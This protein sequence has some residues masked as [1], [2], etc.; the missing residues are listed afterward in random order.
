MIRNVTSQITDVAV[1]VEPRMVL[2]PT[3]PCI[4]MWPG[5]P[6]TD[7]E[8]AGFGEVRGGFLV[9]VRCRV[10]PVDNTAGQ[11]LLLAFGDDEDDLSLT[12]ALTDDP[13][14]NGHGSL[15]VRS[16]SGWNLFPVPNGES[17]VGFLIGVEVIKAQS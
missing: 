10:S 17:L 1:Q 6:A 14:L 11:D 3:P 4:D 15:D 8:T 7:P 5:D 13:T 12:N 9:T 16:Q 2:N